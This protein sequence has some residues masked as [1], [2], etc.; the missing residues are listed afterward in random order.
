MSLGIEVLTPDDLA[1]ET[2]RANSVG[3]MAALQEI[4]LRRKMPSMNV[5]NL[6][7]RWQ[8]QL[9]GFVALARDA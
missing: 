4:A 8:V 6:L 2:L 7:E 1:V 3:V 9:P 5:G